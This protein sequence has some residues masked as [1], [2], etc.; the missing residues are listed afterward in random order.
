MSVIKKN[1]QYADGQWRVASISKVILN[2]VQKV[3][4]TSHYVVIRS[5]HTE[6]SFNLPTIRKI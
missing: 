1:W 2:P 6:V 4:L 5:Y 3:A